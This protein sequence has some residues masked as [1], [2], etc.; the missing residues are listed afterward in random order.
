MHY[1]C[2]RIGVCAAVIGAY[3]C[4]F[5]ASYR[6]RRSTD[7]IEIRW[8]AVIAGDTTHRNSRECHDSSSAAAATFNRRWYSSTS[9]LATAHP[10]SQFDIYSSS[11]GSAKPKSSNSFQRFKLIS[12][13]GIFDGDGH[14]AFSQ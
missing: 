2:D 11:T 6:N 1:Q 4:F 10:Q 5:F 8:A 7:Y 13:G 14:P 3:T 9:R 12:L